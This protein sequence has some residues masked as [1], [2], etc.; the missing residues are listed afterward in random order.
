MLTVPREVG[1]GGG[2]SSKG[3]TYS[4]AMSAAA[5]QQHAVVAGAGGTLGAAV[6]EQVLGAGG[7]AQVFVLADGHIAP[8]LRGFC[9]VDRAALEAGRAAA[10]TAFV[11][12]DRAHDAAAGG[13]RRSGARA[14]EQAF[15]RPDP[16]ALPALAA[17][18][19][20]AGVQRLLLVLPH[21]PALLPQALK[22][23]LASLD[24]HAVAALGFV[25]L[26]IL[27]PSQD[28]GDAARLPLPQRLARWMLAQLRWMI[29][30]REQPVRPQKVA[31]LAVEIARAL[32][33]APPGTR[34]VPPELVWQA[35]QPQQDMAALV[36]G[37]LGP[38]DGHR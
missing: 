17:T 21:A 6:L 14:R 37:W 10:A 9:A 36:R 24:E 2:V 22:A 13:L 4:G 35:A 19:Q 8:A 16:L 12:V 3:S 1:R 32:P 38:Q 30:Q 27:R 23:G 29:P 34:V 18:L 15:H 28:A 5:M 31:A 25:Q 7:Y 11:I 20:R 33:H 26:V